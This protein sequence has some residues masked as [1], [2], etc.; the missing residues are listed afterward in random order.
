MSISNTIMSTTS[1]T[2]IL[3]VVTTAYVLICAHVKME[4]CNVPYLIPIEISHTIWLLRNNIAYVRAIS[5][6]T[7]LVHLITTVNK[8]C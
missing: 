2:S 7:I 4:S 8:I 1:I 3:K 5:C 6:I